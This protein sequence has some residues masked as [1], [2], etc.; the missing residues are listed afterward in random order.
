MTYIFYDIVAKT[1]TE[2]T[3]EMFEESIKNL[4]TNEV[5]FFDTKDFQAYHSKNADKVVCL[6]FKKEDKVIGFCYLGLRSS[7]E[8]NLL[9]IP[10]SSPF[11]DFYFSIKADDIDKML[12]IRGL[13]Q[14]ANEHNADLKITLPP[15]IYDDNL[16]FNMSV[17]LD[18]NIKLQ[19]SHINNYIDLKAISS[20]EDFSSDRSHSFRKNLA[21]AAKSNLTLLSNQDGIL[22]RAFKVIK[23]NREQKNYPL[24]MGYEQILDIS[25]MNDARIDS[26]V[27]EDN[28][29]DIAAAIVFRI[30][31][32][33]VQV[34]YWGALD[35]YSKLRPM[36]FLAY[37]L[38]EHY[39]NKGYEFLDIGPSTADYKVN[40]GLLKF[41]KNIGCSTNFKPVFYGE[42]GGLVDSE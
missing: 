42:L 41:K 36:E 17:L 16:A 24:A 30:N 5:L 7:E 33:T 13:K 38:V 26:F 22:N 25:N 2:T 23:I 11:S 29:S 14:I 9:L 40:Y 19:Y 27:V 34:I 15:E 31:L 37:S 8:K 39:K 3:S 20:M 10:Y 21:R 12:S 32:K 18:E 1:T 6:G 28:Y 4:H 35:E